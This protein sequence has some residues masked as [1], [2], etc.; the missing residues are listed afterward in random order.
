MLN[1]SGKSNP[2]K[3][4]FYADNL[5]SI[6]KYDFNN[7]RIE[8][9]KLRFDYDVT[10]AQMNNLL[11]DEA[12]RFKDKPWVQIA[13]CLF[14]SMA[15]FLSLWEPRIFFLAVSL[16]CFLL[17]FVL[18]IYCKRIGVSTWH[19]AEH[20]A[21][22]AYSKWGTTDLDKI[23]KAP[24]VNRDCGAGILFAVVLPISLAGILFA[25]VSDLPAFNALLF[26]TV[27]VFW[28]YSNCYINRR[29]IIFIWLSYLLQYFFTTQEP[30]DIE[31][32]TA[33]AALIS[34]IELANENSL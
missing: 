19:G 33:Q 8:V 28:A 10:M 3:I 2:G 13:G 14:C 24:R 22:F 12:S 6:A 26:W 20:K 16:L 18:G 30:S 23:K 21:I 34:L 32:R 9:S 15:I 27:V 1:I 25:T 5:I 7:Q 11:D 31:L 17:P 4:G 29:F